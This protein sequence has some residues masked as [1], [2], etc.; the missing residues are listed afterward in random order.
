APAAVVAVG[1]LV[2]MIS[3]VAVR[4]RAAVVSMVP[5]RALV[6][7]VATIDRSGGVVPAGAGAIAMVALDAVV[8]AVAVSVSVA[9]RPVVARAVAGSPGLAVALVSG[10]VSLMDESLSVVHW[11]D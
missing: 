11:P 6:P 10:Q 3:V 8:A 4:P 9:V 2:P 1:A 7:L 5:V